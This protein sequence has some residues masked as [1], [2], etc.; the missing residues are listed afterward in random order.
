MLLADIGWVVLGLVLLILGGEALVRSASTFAVRAGIS[1]LVIGLLVVSAATSAPEFAVTLGA[2]LNGEPGLAIGNVVGSNI[3]NI[4]LILGLSAVIS[5]LIIKRQLVRVDVPIMVGLSV[6]LVAVSLDGQI[7]LLDGVLLL[8]G[9]VVHAIISIRLGRREVREAGDDPETL[10]LN[11]QPVPLWLAAIL[12]AL[13][14]GL[15]VGGAQ[16]LVTGAVNIATALGVSGLVVGLTVVAIGTSLPELAT[17]IIAIRRGERDMAVGNIVGS[18]IFNIGMVLGLPAILFGEGIPVPEAA[19]AIDLPLMLAASVALLPL[20]FTG[21]ILAR[22]EGGLFLLLY[23]AYLLFV[24][25]AS[26][27]HD[28]AEGFTSVMLWFV[29]PL[30]G[31]ILLAVTFFEL[32]VYR[33]RAIARGKDP[34]SKR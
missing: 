15:L 17:S 14:V 2:V 25:L 3:A 6:L 12:L 9:L 7:G 4:L 26:T 10:P 16:S 31:I 5:P 32:G 30:V 11:S 28:A 13:G 33:G 18:N 1:P 19:I 34:K 22:W 20:A 29:L 24:V 27:E 21:F 8:A 23:T